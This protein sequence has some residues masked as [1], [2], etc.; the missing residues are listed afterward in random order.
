MPKQGPCS[1]DIHE[2]PWMPMDIHGYLS[3][4]FHGYP[5]ISM[6]IHGYPSVWFLGWVNPAQADAP[7]AAAAAVV[8]TYVSNFSIGYPGHTT[9]R[10][11]GDD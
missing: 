7:T 2:Y 3:M 1:M 9:D 11:C 10:K 6:D 5:W 8:V 4:D